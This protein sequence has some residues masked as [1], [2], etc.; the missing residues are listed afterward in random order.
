MEE[1]K[2]NYREAACQIKNI[3]DAMLKKENYMDKM[4]ECI[5]SINHAI[6]SLIEETGGDASNILQ[7]L[8]DMMY[9]MSQ[10]DEVF[11]LDVLRFGILPLLEEG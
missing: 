6:M 10:Q 5:T 9:G 3:C 4:P 7:V 2:K 8:E 11:L 1:K